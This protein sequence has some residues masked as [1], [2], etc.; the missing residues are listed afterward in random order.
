MK[1]REKKALELVDKG[2]QLRFDG[3]PESAPKVEKDLKKNTGRKP[4]TYWR[5]KKNHHIFEVKQRV[6]SD[7]ENTIR[8]PECS[9][10]MENAVNKS[11]YMYYLNNHGRGDKKQYIKRFGEKDN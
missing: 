2:K 9:S 1:K 7:R 5:C 10:P 11:T 4:P 3:I 8:C 6:H